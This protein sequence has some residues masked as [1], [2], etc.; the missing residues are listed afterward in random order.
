MAE[1]LL[2]NRNEKRVLALLLIFGLLIVIIQPLLLSVR[3]QQNSSI[4]DKAY[5][6]RLATNAWRYFQ[7]GV[8]VDPITGLE[9][10]G[11]SFPLFTDWDLGAYIQSVIDAN[12]LGILNTTGAWGAN[13]RFDIILDFLENRPLGPNS[14]PCNWYKSS[15]GYPNSYSLQNAADAGALLVALN[16]LRNY[17][18]DLAETINYIVYN[19]T[20]YVP[21]EQAIAASSNSKNIYDYYVLS[22]FADFW[23]NQFSNLPGSILNNILSAPTVSTYGVSLPIS[24]LTC[25]PLLLSVFNLPRNPKLENLAELLYSSQEARYDAT[26]KFTAFSEGDTGLDDPSYV[27]EWVVKEDGSTWVVENTQYNRVGIAPIIYL[28]SAVDLLAMFNTSFTGKMASYIESRLPSP[29]TGYSDGIDE[30]GRVDADVIGNANAMIIEAAEYAINGSSSTL[31]AA[32]L[33]TPTP[34]PPATTTPIPPHTLLSAINPTPLPSLTSTSTPSPTLTAIPTPTPKP[35]PTVTFSPIQRTY[36]LITK[37]I[38]IL[39]LAAITATA[40]VLIKRKP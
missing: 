37:A 34:M 23:P 4:V 11:L 19:R 30:N 22:G 5:W 1:I 27:Y 21:L 2:V 31:K 15:D 24:T 13:E 40:I 33:T 38:I 16:N 17:R 26:G 28:K 6:Q 9:S 8:G 39:A 3:G 25:D 29:T 32:T 12:N 14:L 20:N 7:P 36:N 18:P 35:I 10:A